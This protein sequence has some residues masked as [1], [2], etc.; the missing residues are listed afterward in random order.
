MT[1]TFALA[2]YFVIDRHRIA[3]FSRFNSGITDV[4][5]LRLHLAVRQRAQCVHWRRKVVRTSEYTPLTSVNVFVRGA[6]GAILLPLSHVFPKR[7]Q[8]A[9]VKPGLNFVRIRKTCFC[10]SNNKHEAALAQA[11]GAEQPKRWLSLNTL[12][13]VE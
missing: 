2:A 6:K 1:T 3:R 10:L 8:G 7:A 4:M 11:S 13:P 12:G 9:M 5:S